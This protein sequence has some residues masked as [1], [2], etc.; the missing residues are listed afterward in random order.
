[1]DELLLLDLANKNDNYSRLPK[2]KL[3]LTGIRWGRQPKP[4]EDGFLIL[5]LGHGAE[6]VDDAASTWE[7][8][9][10]EGSHPIPNWKSIEFCGA[11]EIK[12]PLYPKDC[13]EFLHK[14][15]ASQMNG[16]GSGR[17]YFRLE[18][19]VKI[20]MGDAVFQ[21]PI[22]WTIFLFERAGDGIEIFLHD[23]SMP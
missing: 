2:A 21:V 18:T 23:H 11:N 4:V 3:S 7:I 13:I 10:G 20:A 6:F 17:T 22:A 9:A 15:H 12:I 19:I 1:M 5:L 8:Q 16:W 14:D